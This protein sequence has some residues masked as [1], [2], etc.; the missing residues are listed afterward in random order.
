MN[1]P[2]RTISIFCLLLFLALMLNA[3]YLQYWKA[4]ELND[5]PRNRRVIAGVVLPRARR[6]PGRADAGRAEP[7]RRRPVQVPAHLPRSR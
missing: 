7:C 6:D 5:D 3:T 1:K 4:G 2:I